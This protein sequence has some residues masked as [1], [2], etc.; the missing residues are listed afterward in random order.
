MRVLLLLRGAPGCGKSTWI[1]KNGLKQYALSADDIRLMCCSPVLTTDGL[2]KINVSNDRVVWDE[3]FKLLQ[4]RMENGAFTVVDA[5][6]SKT[7]EMNRYKDLC[8][9]YKYRMFCVDFTGVPIEVCKE[10]NRQRDEYKWV[11]EEAIDKMYA[12]FATQKIP[13]GIKV[14][15]PDELDKIWMRKIDLSQ[16]R[17]VHHVGD[18][19]GCYTA[20]M[21]YVE[22]CGGIKDDEFWIFT[23]D[24]L[25]RGLENAEVLN[26][27]LGIYEKPNVLLLEG[28]HERWLWIWA[29]GGVGKSQEFEFK[30]RPQLEAAG[31]DPKE[32][33]KFYRRLGQCAWYSMGGKD[34][35]VNHAG[36]STL[37]ENPTLIPSVQYIK[38]VG[39]YNDFALVEDSFVRNTPD[40][41]F[42]IHG[43]RNTKQR[44]VQ[45]NERVFNL[46][47]GVEFGGC[48]R[49]VQVRPGGDHKTV[50]IANT[51]FEQRVEEP[52]DFVKA[53]HSVGD[54]I[55]EMRRNRYIQEKKFGNIS[56]FNFTKSAFYEKAW[57]EQTVK[58]RGFFIDTERQRIVARAYEKFFNINEMPETKLDM[59]QYKLSFPVTAYVKENGFLGIVSWNPETGGLFV[60]SKSDPTGEFSAWL[61]SMML[62][63]LSQETLDA[64]RD[65]ARDNS[66]SF[67]FECVDMVHDPHVIEYPESRLYL[68]DIIYN[69][70]SFRKLSYKQ[71]AELAERFG[72]RCKEKAFVIDTWPEFFDW[73]YDVLNE[74]YLYNGRHIEGFVVEDQT[75]YMVKLKLSYYHFWKHLRGV[76]HETIRKGYLNPKKMSSLTTALS[77]QFYGWIRALREA[78]YDPNTI[79]RDICTLRRWFFE[80]DAGKPFREES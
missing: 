41:I 6:N 51:V 59:L 68:L 49:C 80:S 2:T 31:I 42:Q 35:L 66:V 19:H 54:L 14:I 79:P 15:K 73:Y 47:G 25:D 40:N 7:T 75:G 17:C 36:I 48:L 12:R 27:L 16:Y 23:G 39:S 18:I 67:V 11:P 71:T 74:D 10:R 44:P 58:A 56:S 45:A 21:E 3:L 60:T 33:R 37:P 28:N 78:A 29:N 8:E 69:D 4:I 63:T 34:Y 61:Y 5:T 64:I 13:S 30:T 38:G 55:L 65:Y 57:D 62:D 52:E 76:A 20:L 43:H 22:G 72:L 77:N 26:F 46:D 50:E 53:K 1:E 9:Q 32:I 70:V 24:Y